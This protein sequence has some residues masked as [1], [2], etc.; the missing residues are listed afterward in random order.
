V[1]NVT[2]VRHIATVGIRV[3]MYWVDTLDFLLMIKNFKNLK[4]FKTEG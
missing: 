1:P 2:K 4:N 3:S